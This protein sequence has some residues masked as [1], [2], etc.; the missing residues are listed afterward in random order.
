MQMLSVVISMECALFMRGPVNFFSSVHIRE[1]TKVT[2][3]AVHPGTCPLYLYT[4]YAISHCVLLMRSLDDF[5]CQVLLPFTRDCTPTHSS[6]HP[7]LLPIILCPL[8]LLANS[9]LAFICL[10]CRKALYK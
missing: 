9:P 3:S 8:P 4:I 7:F 10:E 5:C 1:D 2:L 6:S